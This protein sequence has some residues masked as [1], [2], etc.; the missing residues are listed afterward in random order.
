MLDKVLDRGIG[1]AT[2]TLEHTGDAFEQVT[3]NVIRQ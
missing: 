1:K 2:Q 3:I